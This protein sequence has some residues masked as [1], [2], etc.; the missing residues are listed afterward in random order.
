LEKI[1]GFTVLTGSL[2][3][4][5][6]ALEIFHAVAPSGERGLNEWQAARPV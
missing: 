4:V 3:F 2:Y 6:Q 5:G 1:N